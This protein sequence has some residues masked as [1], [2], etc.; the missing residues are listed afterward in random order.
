[1][2]RL[3]H[4]LL[5]L[6]AIPVPAWAETI[7]PPAKFE[8]MTSGKTLYFDRGGQPYGAETYLANRQ[9]LWRYSDGTCST[10]HWFEDAGNI[11]FVYDATP[12]PQCWIFVERDG[13]FF[14]R[15][16]GTPSEDIS[17]IRLAGESPEPLDCP[18]PN[19]GF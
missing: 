2:R 6:A 15:T 4:I 18:A 19:L 9:V 7:V 10:G 12:L 8:R 16:L 13:E 11:C 17:E 14:A 3:V 5:A 1:L